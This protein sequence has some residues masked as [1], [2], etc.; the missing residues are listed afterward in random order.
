M[1]KYEKRNIPNCTLLTRVETITN[2]PTDLANMDEFDSDQIGTLHHL[3]DGLASEMGLK[4]ISLDFGNS[5]CYLSVDRCD[6]VSFKVYPPLFHFY[7]T[8]CLRNAYPVRPSGRL[9][10]SRRCPQ[11]GA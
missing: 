6:L 5:D 10:P 7:H 3:V 4:V 8:N 9:R 1:A 2:D 11:T